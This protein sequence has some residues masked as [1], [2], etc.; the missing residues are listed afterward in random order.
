[1]EIYPH[2]V[3]M[4]VV[5]SGYVLSDQHLNF[6]STLLGRWHHRERQQEHAKHSTSGE[7]M[8]ATKGKLSLAAAGAS[9]LHPSPGILPDVSFVGSTLPVFTALLVTT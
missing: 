2:D 5:T 4:L 1:M 3:Y 7:R 8:H 9:D 6:A